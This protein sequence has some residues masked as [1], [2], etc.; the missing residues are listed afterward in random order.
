MQSVFRISLILSLWLKNGLSDS[1]KMWAIIQL[2]KTC[3]QMSHFSCSFVILSVKNCFGWSLR[4]FFPSSFTHYW[5]I[6]FHAR[7]FEL[8]QTSENNTRQ[9]L[10]C[11][12]EG[13]IPSNPVLQLQNDSFYQQNAAFAP[14]C[15]FNFEIQHL[16]IVIA[17]GSSLIFEQ[18]VVNWTLWVPEDNQLDTV[19]LIRTLSKRLSHL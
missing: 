3:M 16:R 19:I 7:C 10:D 11:M 18:I 8:V 9:S 15:W 13:A 1:Y 5:H 2:A 17:I 4:N 14:N 6:F 12:H